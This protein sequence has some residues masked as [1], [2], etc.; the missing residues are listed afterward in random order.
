MK[1]RNG[2][3]SNSSTSS[4]CIYGASINSTKAEEI[5][6]RLKIDRDKYKGYDPNDVTE[7]LEGY[8]S[9]KSNLDVENP[10]SEYDYGLYIGLSW[11]KMK[12]DETL[13]EFKSRIESEIKEVINEELKCSI[14]SEAWSNY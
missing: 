13:A 3:V 9:D 2:F 8:V 11:D 7:T 6:N 14:C 4:F 10:P 1:V 12:D 5:I